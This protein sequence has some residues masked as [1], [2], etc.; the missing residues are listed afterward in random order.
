MLNLSEKPVPRQDGM[1]TQKPEFKGN[2]HPIS[3]ASK[4]SI[5]SGVSGETKTSMPGKQREVCHKLGSVFF[6]SVSY[7][8][9]STSCCVVGGVITCRLPLQLAKACQKCVDWMIGVISVRKWPPAHRSYQILC[10]AGAWCESKIF[11]FHIPA[12]PK[13]RSSHILIFPLQLI[14]F[15]HLRCKNLSDHA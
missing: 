4:L 1:S 5:C 11:P 2:R 13:A 12:F 7:F 3:F 14:S 9:M 8:C 15:Q 6:L 10:S